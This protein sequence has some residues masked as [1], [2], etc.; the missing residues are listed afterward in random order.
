MKKTDATALKRGI[1]VRDEN[2]PDNSAKFWMP[3]LWFRGAAWVAEYELQANEDSVLVLRKPPVVRTLIFVLAEAM[4]MT[5]WWLPH[6][7][8]PVRISRGPLL[9]RGIHTRL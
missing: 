9:P 8:P 4:G 1:L 7:L 5:F 3:A 2:G 6:P